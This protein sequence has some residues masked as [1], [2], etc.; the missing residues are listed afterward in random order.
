[1]DLIMGI[2]GLIL[3]VIII[4]VASRIYGIIEGGIRKI[5]K[6]ILKFI[7]GDRK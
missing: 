7:T 2:G 5:L 4:L 6:M 3:L 1:M